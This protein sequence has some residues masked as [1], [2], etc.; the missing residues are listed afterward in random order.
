METFMNSPLL[1]SVSGKDRPGLVKQIA[2]VIKQSGGNWL[3]SRL[4]HLG[5]RFAGLILA[6]FDATQLEN[7]RQALIELSHD[8]LTISVEPTC[9]ST[10]GD[11]FELQLVGNDKP[12]IVY[13]I[14]QGL[15]SLGA[16]VEYFRSEVNA[17]PMSGGQLFSATL[18]VSLPEGVTIDDVKRRLEQLANDLMV[19]IGFD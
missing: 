18:K 15:D 9:S 5:G 17:A 14:T 13:E 7:A 8:D 6:E 3:E 12:G 11:V 19:D 4:S 16:N 1:I 2:N 10:V